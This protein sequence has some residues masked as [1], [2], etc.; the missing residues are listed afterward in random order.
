MCTKLE[1]Y[2]FCRST[3]I[4]VAPRIYSGSCDHD[5]A[6]LRDNLSSQASISHGHTVHKILVKLQYCHAQ[7]Q[8]ARSERCHTVDA[9]ELSAVLFCC[10]VIDRHACLSQWDGKVDNV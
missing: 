6:Q 1:D 7:L 3:N 9:K 2:S 4:F 8:C 10:I 5:H